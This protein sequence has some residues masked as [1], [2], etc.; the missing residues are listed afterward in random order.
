MKE[1]DVS[2][3]EKFEEEWKRL[4]KER[5]DRQRLPG[6]RKFPLLFRGQENSCWGLTTT[7]ERCGH[8]GM[9][10][11][12]YYESI[13]R[14]K[15]EVET[16]TEG[17]WEIPEWSEL[18]K[19]MESYEPFA[20]FTAQDNKTWGQAYRYMVYL[21]HHGFPSPLLD[22]THLP[23][24][25]AFFA[26]WKRPNKADGKVSIYVYCESPKGL[27]VADSSGQI[28]VHKPYVRT[29][30]RHVIQ[31]C[32]YTLCVKCE[33]VGK[34]PSVPHEEVFTRD[35]SNDISCQDVCWKF[36]IPM[37]ERLKVLNLL[38]N[39]NLNAFS[40][41]G[42]EESLMETMALRALEFQEKASD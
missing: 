34:W 32:E 7:L 33:G 4:Q 29:H 16:F 30:R 13:H 8:K 22:W 37:K 14:A 11:G 18:E 42:S 6:R 12:K 39:Y 21:R 35:D 28:N 40:L 31:Q 2:N 10:F 41:F 19:M 17:N 1:I 25:A 20:A 5:E 3:W 26:F 27:K 9:P 38:D 15:Y 36:N 23:Y 24:V